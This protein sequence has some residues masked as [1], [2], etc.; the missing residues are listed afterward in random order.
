MNG[1]CSAMR[2]IDSLSAKQ[3]EIKPKLQVNTFVLC[4]EKT[5]RVSIHVWAE[6]T[7]GCLKISGQDL[8]QAPLEFFGEDEYEYFYTFDEKNT[9]RLI[10]LLPKGCCIRERMI[11]NFGG[12]DGLKRL[13]EFCEKNE[14][15][16]EFS[17]WF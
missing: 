16:Y 12:A 9:G 3:N 13:R 15:K 5:D 7:D 1:E 4:D 10:G 2:I 14:I 11:D 6:I 8:G 17:N